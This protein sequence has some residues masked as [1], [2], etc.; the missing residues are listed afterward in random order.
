MAASDIEGW[1]PCVRTIVASPSPFGDATRCRGAAEPCPPRP[2]PGVRR[3]R[4]CS[5]A[6]DSIAPV[7]SSSRDAFAG[8]ASLAIRIDQQPHAPTP[9]GRTAALGQAPLSAVDI[10]YVVG[11]NVFFPAGKHP[12]PILWGYASPLRRPPP[13]PLVLGRWSHQTSSFAFCDAVAS[14]HRSCTRPRSART[15]SI[16]T[17]TRRV[18]PPLEEPFRSQREQQ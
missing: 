12:P 13:K 7:L 10:R 3:L 1:L 5:C 18:L 11:L 8:R 9:P 4:A 14:H 16:M 17:D 2:Q 15:R 6:I